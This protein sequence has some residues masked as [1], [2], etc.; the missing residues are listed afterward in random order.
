MARLEDNV[1]TSFMQNR[2]LSWMKF[3]ERVLE[4]A[5]DKTVPLY[6]RLKFISI[7][8]SNLDEF[9]MIRVGS[10]TDLYLMGNHTIDNKT[11]MSPRLQRDK[12]LENTIPLYKLRDRIYS[13]VESGLREFGICNLELGELNKTEKKYVD[14]YFRDNLLPVL[15]PQVIGIKHPFPHLQNKTLYI[16][17]DFVDEEKEFGLIPV[18]SFLPEFILMPGNNTRY[19]LTEK[20]ILGYLDEILK[21]YQVNTA[22]II[23]VTRN[24][25]ISKVDE[26][27]EVDD[28]YREKM[29]R[30]IKKRARL[31]PVRLEVQGHLSVSVLQFL[32]KK[33]EIR[34][35]QL[36]FSD[37]PLLMNY[38]YKIPIMLKNRLSYPYFE[39]G[40]PVSVNIN[41]NITSQC[42]KKDILL[43]YPY[44]KMDPFL[45]L[46]KES[47]TD[48]EVISIQITIYRVSRNSRII[49]YLC[50]AAENKKEVTVLI[51]LKARFDEKNNIEWAE[52]LEESGCNVIYGFENFKV[53]AKI[54]LITRKE[55]DDIV[56]ITQ[57]GTGNYNEKT[58]NL[59]ADL[60]L[61]TANQEIG[62]DASKFFKNMSIS[63]LNGNYNNLLVAPFSFK[64]HV[65]DHIDSEI[66]KAKN[67]NNARV[68]IKLNSL[69]D[70]DIIKK[71]SL[72]S[73]AGVKIT[74]IIRGIC[75]LLP[76]IPGKTDNIRVIS[77]VGRFLEHARIYCFGEGDET[78]LY[79]A[80]ADMMTRNT[81]RR[82]EI[83]CPILDNDIKKDIL[84]YLNIMISDNVKGRLLQP[85]G[86]YRKDHMNSDNLIESHQYFIDTLAEPNIPSTQIRR[87]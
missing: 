19:V 50:T 56:Y 53:H 44:Q 65:M 71:L 87:L 37:A 70:I 52:Q 78:K 41:E 66:E 42:K 55:K 20:I 80:S 34:E 33:L 60:S 26:T 12:I 54:C 47:A 16:I 9:Y 46:L 38:V 79:I 86:T 63:N 25:D 67:G 22:A 30:V 6:E 43:F 7:F 49:D 29:K 35:S 73:M 72:A 74:L 83:A 40:Y 27:F 64:C 24:A 11:G 77:I 81:S 75:C 14:N 84:Q 28:E 39:A 51:E 48:P 45:H 36:F 85:D 31:S 23:S 5:M 32:L 15:S 21:M 1:D 17:C 59:Y 76:G 2:E 18:S 68:I 58:A 8:T 4:E 82:V 10:L 69:T 3:N 61:I 13:E 57:V 62:K